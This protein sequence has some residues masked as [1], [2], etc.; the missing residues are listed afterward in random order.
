MKT[1]LSLFLN[2]EIAKA[3]K[4]QAALN[5]VKVSKLIESIFSCQVCNQP[6]T[7]TPRPVFNDCFDSFVHQ[8]CEKDLEKF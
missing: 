6:I 3:I 4:V 1:K 5:G 7:D 8:Y 2:P